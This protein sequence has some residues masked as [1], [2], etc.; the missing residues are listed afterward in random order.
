MLSELERAA[1]KNG[2]GAL[3]AWVKKANEASIGLPRKSGYAR[4]ERPEN[5]GIFLYCKKL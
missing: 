2:F 5:D 1:G 4:A 3:V